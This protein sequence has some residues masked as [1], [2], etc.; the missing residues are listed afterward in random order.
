MTYDPALF[1]IGSVV[2][3]PGLAGCLSVANDTTPGMLVVAFLCMAGHSG[4]PL[5]VWVVTFIVADVGQDQQTQLAITET[6]LG[7]IDGQKIL[8]AGS[9]FDVSV[10]GSATSEPTAVG[11][12]TSFLTGGS[13]SSASIAFTGG[14]FMA[15]VAI[16]IA[17]GCCARRRRQGKES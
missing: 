7:D 1:S 15:V 16:A 3:G 12:T 4:T 10:S 13:G 9:V 6:L 8:S 2:L 17:A 14:G 5:T 11:G